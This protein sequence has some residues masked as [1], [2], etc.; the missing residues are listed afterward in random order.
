[1][2][3]NDLVQ[4][5]NIESVTK[6]GDKYV[7]KIGTSAKVYEN[8]DYYFK[9]IV[10][11]K[12]KIYRHDEPLYTPYGSE[13][14]T[15][16]K[17]LAKKA[18]IDLNEYGEMYEFAFSIISFFY[19]HIDFTSSRSIE[20]LKR[21]IINDFSIDWTFDCPCK[22]DDSYVKWIKL[23]GKQDER[24]QVIE[25]WLNNLSKHQLGGIIMMV[26]SLDSSNIAYMLSENLYPN[27]EEFAGIVD[28]GYILYHEEKGDGMYGYFNNEEKVKIFKNYLFWHSLKI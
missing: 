28:E 15:G 13:V 1:M 5:I 21:P 8:A 11:G 24:Q 10:K 9:E 7:L 17:S 12:Y 20:E 6:E 18:I 26:A 14:V 3:K 19:S 27:L 4:P 23:F 25:N 22:D 2:E 16:N